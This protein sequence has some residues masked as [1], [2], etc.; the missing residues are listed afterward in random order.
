LERFQARHL[1]S[2][3]LPDIVHG[4][5]IGPSGYVATCL[6]RNSVVTV[7][8][9]IQVEARMAARGQLGSLRVR[10]VDGR[11]RDVLQRAGVVISTS[12]YD[13]R[14]L[15]GVVR[16][17]RVSIPNP[18]PYEFFQQV[19][20]EATPPSILYAGMLVSRKN[21]TGLLRA[22]ALVHRQVPEARLV[23]VGPM[24][25]RAYLTEVKTLAA[26]LCLD[27]VV[28]FKGFVETPVL[29]RQLRQA[30]VLAMFSHEETSPTILAQALAASKPVV[31]SNVGGIPELVSD[32]ENGFLVE[33]GD[34]V[35]LA[36]R[37]T[38][39]VNSPDLCRAFSLHGHAFACQRFEPS[40]V[41]RQT[42]QA[43]RVLLEN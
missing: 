41:A 30:R 40:A 3:I 42:L 28:D 12:N 16:G 29:L 31:A 9:L 26:A 22:F 43:Y 27:Q 35:A 15:D 36:D 1:A 7:H 4:Q 6:N 37:L 19:S 34:E 14:S 5:G 39:L 11:V 18:V 25:D 24:P 10:M 32:G 20:Y 38:T 13:A 21:V 2:E 23:I 8:G 33:P 17:L